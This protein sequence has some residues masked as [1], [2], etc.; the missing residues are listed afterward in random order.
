MITE[1]NVVS[2]F[3]QAN[4]VPKDSCTLMIAIAASLQRPHLAAYALSPAAPNEL[5]GMNPS[6][7]TRGASSD[8]GGSGNWHR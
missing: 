2:F 1:E 6:L 7:C 3:D 4:P 5:A 8:G